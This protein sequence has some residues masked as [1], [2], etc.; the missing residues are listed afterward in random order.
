MLV[1]RDLLFQSGTCNSDNQKMRKHSFRKEHAVLSGW[2]AILIAFNHGI[3]KTRGAD[4]RQDDYLSQL[5]VDQK[6]PS[7]MLIREKDEWS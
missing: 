2:L 5:L 3:L 1:C 6:C 4:Q 7:G